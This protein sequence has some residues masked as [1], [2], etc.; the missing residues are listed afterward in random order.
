MLQI[1]IAINRPA[2]MAAPLRSL[3]RLT[4]AEQRQD[5]IV[6]LPQLLARLTDREAVLKAAKPML[7]DASREAPLAAP[8]WSSLG[9]FEMAAGQK[10]A[11]LESARKAMAADSKSALPAWLVLMLLEQKQEGA[12]TLVQRWLAQDKVAVADSQRI[13]LEYA[14]LL[15][16]QQRRDEAGRQLAIITRDNPGVAEPWLLQGLLALQ[17]GQPDQATT[18]LERYLSLQPSNSRGTMQAR[19]LL[20]E[21]A[22]K[23]G[24]LDLALTWLE[25]V[26]DAEALPAVLSRRALLMARQ[27]RLPEARAL[28]RQMPGQ[29]DADERRK[30]IAEGQLLR[31]L[32]LY[33]EALE[34]YAE[35]MNRFPQDSDI[36]YERAMVAEKAGRLDEMEQWLREL[37]ARAPDYG[38]AYNALGYS[39]AD[40][41]LKLQEARELIQRALQLL[42]DDPFVQDSMGWVEFRL[43]H[44]AESRRWLELAFERRPDAEIATHLGEVLW[45]LGE[46]D[47]ARKVWQRGQQQQ[48][49]NETLQRTLDRL[50]VRP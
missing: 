22:E 38:H 39:L 6:G 27:G 32:A 25:Q 21:A 12:E 16:D 46:Q 48:P 1:L 42:P 11:A 41:K 31:D 4:P 17:S 37:I 13:R 7:L 9:R 8:A 20:S 29:T 10:P 49:G 45:E 23:Q 28:L 50:Q 14:R 15:T 43:G 34:V 30:L 44:L 19:I 40:R 26:E 3:L 35:A 33:P 2:E 36:A 18:A 24:R 5:L 47:A